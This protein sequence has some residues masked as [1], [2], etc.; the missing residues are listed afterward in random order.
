M[1][2]AVGGTKGSATIWADVLSF[3]GQADHQLFQASILPDQKAGGTA[4][5]AHIEGILSLPRPSRTIGRKVILF[6]ENI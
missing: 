1:L 6:I 2:P 5:R 4:F 3:A